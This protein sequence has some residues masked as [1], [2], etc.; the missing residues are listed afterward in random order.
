MSSMLIN[1]ENLEWYPPPPP[2]PLIIRHGP[3]LYSS[4]EVPRNINC[5]RNNEDAYS[6]HVMFADYYAHPCSDLQFFTAVVATS[7]KTF[8]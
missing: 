1:L 8:M 7:Y 2:K 6:A 3:Y 4:S 5:T